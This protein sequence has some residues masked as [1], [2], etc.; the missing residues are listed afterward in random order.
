MA[1]INF[2]VY[3]PV[4]GRIKRTG[5]VPTL[6]TMAKQVREGESVMEGKADPRLHHIDLTGDEPQIVNG[7]ISGA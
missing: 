6:A 2:I 4:T 7:A 1:I 3:D 5:G